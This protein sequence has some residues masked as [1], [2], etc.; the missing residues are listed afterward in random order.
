M[1]FNDGKTWNTP[2]R[3][4]AVD[5]KPGPAG[6]WTNENIA[7]ALQLVDVDGFFNF[8]SENNGIPVNKVGVKA[9]VILS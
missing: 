1:T 4:T 8:H 2:M 3:I 9:S 5:G 6:G 7:T